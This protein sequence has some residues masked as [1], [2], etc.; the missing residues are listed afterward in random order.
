MG[1]VDETQ[2]WLYMFLRWVQDLRHG[3]G[4]H[5]DGPINWSNS[6]KHVLDEEITNFIEF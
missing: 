6:L 2:K 3:K 1:K 5:E 4:L